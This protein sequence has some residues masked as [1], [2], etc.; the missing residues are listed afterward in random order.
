MMQKMHKL[1]LG[2]ILVLS[3]TFATHAQKVA[4]KTN[5]LYDATTTFNLGMEF[6]LSPKWT[7]DVS[8]NYNPWTFDNNQKWKHWMVQPEARYWLCEKFNGHFFGFHFL[9]GQYNAGNI[10]TSLKFLG[11]DFSGLKDNRYEGW[12]AGAGI[13]YGYSWILG[14]HWNFE[15]EIGIGYAYTRYDRYDCAKCGD[16]NG[17]GFHNY[18]GPTK[19]ALSLVYVF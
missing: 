9:G 8:A 13:S 16:K 10:D 1:L 11:N 3:S 17:K 4:L 19:A 15:A 2:L 6:G 12:F 14:K 7:L 5:L 18:V